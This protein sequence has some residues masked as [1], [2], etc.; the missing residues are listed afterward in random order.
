MTWA[1]QVRHVM[2]KD[3]R[4]ARWLLS[5]YLGIVLIAWVRA[6]AWLGTPRT[7]YDI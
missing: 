2:A 7:A 5:G 1:A 4:Q 3:I 6:L